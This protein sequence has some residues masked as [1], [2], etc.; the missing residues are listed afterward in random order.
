M[1]TGFAVAVV[2]E[3]AGR[4]LLGWAAGADARGGRA[5]ARR[6]SPASSIIFVVGRARRHPRRSSPGQ[7]FVGQLLAAGVAIALGLRIELRRQPV[8]RRAHRARR[9][10]ATRSRCFWIVGFANVINLIDGLDGLAAGVT[11]I[12]ATSF[13]VLAAQQNQLVAAAL[14]AALIGACLGFLRYNFNPASIFMGDSGALFLGFALACDV[15]ARRDEVGRGHHARRCRCSSSACRSST[16][17]SAIIRRSAARPADPG[18]RQGAHPSPAARTA[19]STSGRRC[20]SS[21]SGRSRWRSA[22][23]AMRC[24]PGRH[25]VRR[26]RG[27]GACCRASWR[28][29]SA[30]SSGRT[31]TRTIASDAGREPLRAVPC[32]A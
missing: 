18:G 7:K 21:T 31:T 24:A 23:Y 11:A 30:C 12:A 22:G 3:Y 17:R 32:C 13:L 27:A 28:T 20:S 25:Q 4:A 29:G 16:P 9:A 2:V 14:A 19:A 1:F 8:R 15:A 5:D 10:G 26:L 6:R